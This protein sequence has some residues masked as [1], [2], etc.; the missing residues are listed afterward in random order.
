MPCQ[1]HVLVASVADELQQIGAEQHIRS[2]LC[3]GFVVNEQ[4]VGVIWVEWRSTWPLA[5]HVPLTVIL[6]GERTGRSSRGNQ[7]ILMHRECLALCHLLP[8]WIYGYTHGHTILV[9]DYRVKVHSLTHQWCPLCLHRTCRARPVGERY[10]G[11]VL[12]VELVR[13]WRRNDQLHSALLSL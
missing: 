2:I 8:L 1:V 9:H 12:P 13:L 6:I 3:L 7:C 10:V 5:V 11:P 4:I